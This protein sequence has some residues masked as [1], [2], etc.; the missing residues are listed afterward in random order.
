MLVDSILFS[1]SILLFTAGF[2]NHFMMTYFI[3]AHFLLGCIVHWHSVVQHSVCNLRDCP[4][5]HWASFVLLWWR[6]SFTDGSS[7][8]FLLVHTWCHQS[9]VPFYLMMHNAVHSSLWFMGCKC[10]KGH[11]CYLVFLWVLLIIYL[12][13]YIYMCFLSF[14]KSSRHVE[15]FFLVACMISVG[16]FS[17]LCILNNFVLKILD[18]PR[19]S[20]F[21]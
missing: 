17:L 10:S 5:V 18:T 7:C 2:V 9:P 15:H 21:A 8:L 20:T 4:A 6:N 16:K 12:Y 14:F 13:M 11:K 19:Y 1:C 3:S